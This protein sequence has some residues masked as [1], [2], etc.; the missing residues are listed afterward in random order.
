VGVVLDFD[1]A[2]LLLLTL[3][4]PSLILGCGDDLLALTLLSLT[5]GC[6]CDLLALVLFSLTLLAVDGNLLVLSLLSL[7]FLAVGSS[8][9]APLF[10]FFALDATPEVGDRE[11]LAFF[12]LSA[13]TTCS[14]A[15]FLEAALAPRASCTELCTTLMENANRQSISGFNGSAG[16]KN[17]RCSKYYRQA[18]FP[19][20]TVQGC[21]I[22]TSALLRILRVSKAL[23]PYQLL[24]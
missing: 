12:E 2:A 13:A 20:V 17:E 16:F 21:Q 10:P 6:G 22:G 5:F 24:E 14:I 18:L 8:L 1:G 3:P 9:L 19:C 4:L 7:A 23:A 11:L 15:G